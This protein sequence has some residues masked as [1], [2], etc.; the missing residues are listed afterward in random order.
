MEYSNEK[1]EHSEINNLITDNSTQEIYQPDDSDDEVT[2]QSNLSIQESGKQYQNVNSS[3]INIITP[4][5]DNEIH[6]DNEHQ[7]SSSPAYVLTSGGSTLHENEDEELNE[8]DFISE[9]GNHGSN[10]FKP[11]NIY[12]NIL[13]YSSKM[14]VN[15]GIYK[16]ELLLTTSYLLCFVAL[17]ISVGSLGPTLLALA[18]NTNST[19]DKVGYFFSSRGAGYF[20]GSFCARIFDK[21]K[22]GNYVI[23]AAV[24]LMA[25]SLFTIPLVKNIWVCGLVFV[26]EGFA[27]GFLDSG[28]NAM[29]V[30]VWKESV[31]PFMQL[32]HFSF[33]V[34]AFLAPLVISQLVSYSLVTQYMVLAVIMGAGGLMIIFLP[35]AVIPSNE[36][37]SDGEEIS[38]REKR[39]GVEVVASIA[40][41]LFWYVGSEA[42]FG[43]WLS[44]YSQLNLGFTDKQGAL[45]TSLF[46]GTFTLFRFIGVIMS[47][48]M[49]PQQMVVL[50][51]C[52]C[53]FFS[54]LLILFQKSAT[55]LWISTA[56]LGIGLAS[57]FPTAFSLPQNLGFKVTG[58]STS[59]MVIGA[60]LGELTIPWLIGV[61]QHNIG[62]HTLPFVVLGTLI[63]SLA[64]YIAIN[65]RAKY[66]RATD[67]QQD[68]KLSFS[69][70]LELLKS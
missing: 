30:W 54:I 20:V 7:S 67:K 9:G 42:G 14:W 11:N 62:H 27:A 45:I 46:W 49:T 61:M 3:S 28:L 15:A 33:G 12:E 21:V 35:S 64:I 48:V 26:I 37:S 56:G 1:I 10:R 22:N 70:P 52:V 69:T 66:I 65:I 41:F 23:A 4:D 31:N 29:I 63:I 34:G 25:L 16:K 19:L 39:L 38:R 18:E 58:E 13:N 57:I 59:Y 60:T 51:T 53:F 43:G 5:G 2:S 44:S 24:I 50:D 32:L 40:F 6:K 55:V 17:G 36:E 68:F 47:L 8:H